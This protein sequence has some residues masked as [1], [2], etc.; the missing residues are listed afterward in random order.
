MPPRPANTKCRFTGSE[1]RFIK[2]T[3]A[4]ELTADFRGAYPQS[5]R[6]HVFGH[7]KLRELLSQDGCVGLRIYHG[8]GRGKGEVLVLVG[9]DRNGG[10]L[11]AGRIL[12][13]SVPCPSYCDTLS[14]LAPRNLTASRIACSIKAIQFSGN[15]GDYVQ[16][17][18]A[19]KWTA[20]FR[21]TNRASIKAHFF[22]RKKLEALLAQPHCVALRIYNALDKTKARELVIAGVTADNRDMTEG[23]VLDGSISCPRFCSERSALFA[24]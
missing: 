2:P 24:A 20:Q 19:A 22:G 4:A 17:S 18:S 21:E 6:G 10:D 14:V 11:T 23:L 3:V 9:V 16:L 8:L 7:T 13:V 15:E 5:L 1:G 12:D